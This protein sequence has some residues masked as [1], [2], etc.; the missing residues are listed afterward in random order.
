MW[1]SMRMLCTFGSMCKRTDRAVW[2]SMSQDEKLFDQIEV[3]IQ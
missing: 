2:I 1:W 3:D